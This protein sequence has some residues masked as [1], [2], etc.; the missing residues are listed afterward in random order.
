[1]NE[2]IFL[3]NDYS[4]GC[5]EE[6]L[7]K[8]NETNLLKTKGYGEDEFCK[9]ASEKIKKA[10]NCPEA[11]IAAAKVFILTSR[12]E[13]FSNVLVESMSVGTCCVAY[14]CDYGPRNIID[15]EKNGILIP[16]GNIKLLSQAIEEIITDDKKRIRLEKCA[17]EKSVTYSVDNIFNLYYKY[18]KQIGGM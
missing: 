4:E 11:E 15:N 10:C 8:L 12:Y 18:F 5:C 17:K 7:K 6:I 3:L 14:D 9:S 13:G 1:M 16:P 2:K